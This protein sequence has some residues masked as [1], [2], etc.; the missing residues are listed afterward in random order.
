[1]RPE[2]DQKY[3]IHD[4]NNKLA[5]IQIALDILKL[6]EDLEDSE[7]YKICINAFKRA[8]ELNTHLQKSLV[9]PSE[10]VVQKKKEFLHDMNKF[11]SE[12]MTDYFQEFSKLYG[13][14]IDFAYEDLGECMVY[15]DVEGGIRV[16]ENLIENARKAGATKAT[17]RVQLTKD[18][19]SYTFEDNGKGM[20]PEQLQKL[21]LQITDSEEG[22]GNGTKYIFDFIQKFDAV[23]YFTSELGKG[24]KF[25]ALIPTD[26]SYRHLH[27]NSSK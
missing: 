16:D 7:Y 25:H 5:S 24:T 10:Q 22:K 11:V 14:E 17:V 26:K 23:C 19:F 21:H 2:K 18:Y 12:R 27:L 20:T 1:M 3:L 4:L 6:K 13:I 8:V 15:V 9:T